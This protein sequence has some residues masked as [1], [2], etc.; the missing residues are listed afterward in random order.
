MPIRRSIPIDSFTSNPFQ[1]FDKQWFVL[2]CGDFAARKYNCMTISWGSLGI[3]WNKPFAQVVVRPTRFTYGFINEF[4]SFTLCTFADKYR[5][6]MN[7]LGSKSGRDGDK[8]KDSGLTPI[9]SKLVAAPS[10]HEARLVLECR[11]MYWQ[12]FDPHHFLAADIEN[13]YPNKDYHRSLF[14][15]VLAIFGTEKYRLN[16]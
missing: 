7:L 15:E 6:A 2:T 11:K 3:M 4:D 8:I 16:P 10:F 13:K 5:S 1:L 14:G 9:A 12:D